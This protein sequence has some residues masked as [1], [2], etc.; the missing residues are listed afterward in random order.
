METVVLCLSHLE[1]RLL[2]YTLYEFRLSSGGDRHMQDC[3]WSQIHAVR[4]PVT[5][6][7][8]LGADRFLYTGTGNFKI[9]F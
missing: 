1:N 3:L 4:A 7:W 8:I 2:K 5:D 6:M 9:P